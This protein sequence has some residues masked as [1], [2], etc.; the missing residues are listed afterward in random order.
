MIIDNSFKYHLP[1]FFW[2][3][4]IFVQSS[5]PAVELPQIEIISA[6]K[7]AHMGVYG[8][9][10][11][12]CYISLIHQT[13]FN[14]LYSHP[15]TFTILICSV[16]GASDEFHQYFVPNRDCEFFDWLADVIGAII[17][18]LLIKYYL[19]KKFRFLRIN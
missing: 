9:L 14:L 19:T 1:F 5:F 18:V 15:F 16:Y 11:L 12:L 2:L 6:D 8:L 4:V 13:K 7:L 10:A 3:T 17:M